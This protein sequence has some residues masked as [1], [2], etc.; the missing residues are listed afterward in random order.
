MP[1]AL[2]GPNDQL[3][4][5]VSPGTQ[6]VRDEEAAGSQQESGLVACGFSRRTLPGSSSSL[7]SN[8]ALSKEISRTAVCLRVGLAASGSSAE[9]SSQEQRARDGW[10]WTVPRKSARARSS[11]RPASR[12]RTTRTHRPSPHDPA[13]R[14]RI[15]SPAPAEVQ[16]T[17]GGRTGR[18]HEPGPEDNPW[19]AFRKLTRVFGRCRSPS[20]PEPN[21]LLHGLCARPSDAT[22]QRLP[23][24]VIP[25]YLLARQQFGTAAVTT[26]YLDHLCA[27]DLASGGPGDLSASPGARPQKHYSRAR[28]VFQMQPVVDLPM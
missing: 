21:W 8:L 12:R 7:R 10:A 27:D 6:V 26:Q 1:T 24:D 5:L 17:P 20:A 2:S 3:N 14:P 25:A 18:S 23:E 9:Q 19:A 13:V 4:R 22:A 11:R 15:R 16:A 28:R